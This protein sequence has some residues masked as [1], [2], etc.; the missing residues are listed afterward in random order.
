M[1]KCVQAAA[2]ILAA[3]SFTTTFPVAA[4]ANDAQLRAY[5]KQLSSQCTICH[6]IDGIDNG[7]PSI[8]GWPAEDFV[9]VLKTYKDGGRADAA[10]VRA[11]QPLDDKQMR[12]LASFFASLKVSF[13]LR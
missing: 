13:P 10:M 2:G 5:G 12:A 4:Q 3:A 9:F 1:R 11:A 7:V 8:V 6:R